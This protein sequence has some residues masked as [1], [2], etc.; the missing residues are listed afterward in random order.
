MR[1]SLSFSLILIPYINIFCS[2]V[3]YEKN[4]DLVR[5]GLATSAERIHQNH[6]TFK[7]N[8]SGGKNSIGSPSISTETFA[9]CPSCQSSEILKNYTINEVKNHILKTLGMQ[10][11]P[12]TMFQRNIDNILVDKV[13]NLQKE[14]RS[15][16]SNN[17]PIESSIETEK[18][19]SYIILA[20][21][22][23]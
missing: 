11:G 10:N 3:S 17:L 4:N 8:S 20:E 12:P 5:K 22:R 23:K 18:S 15:N 6:K 19:N 2:F 16:P 1:L 9:S 21:F 14:A 13:F 7:E